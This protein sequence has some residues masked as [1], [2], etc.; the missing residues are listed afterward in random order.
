MYIGYEERSSMHL[1]ET[2][3]IGFMSDLISESVDFKNKIFQYLDSVE[4]RIEDFLKWPD[5]VSERKMIKTLRKKIKW[6]PD[7]QFLS[8]LVRI[9]YLKDALEWWLWA[10]MDWGISKKEFLFHKKRLIKPTEN[11]LF[12][13]Q[14]ECDRIEK[15][16]KLKK[17]VIRSMLS[18]TEDAKV[19]LF[20]IKEWEELS[21]QLLISSFQDSLSVNQTIETKVWRIQTRIHNILMIGT[22][23]E[24]H[25]V[26][27]QKMEKRLKEFK[28]QNNTKVVL[29]SSNLLEIVEGLLSEWVDTEFV[30]PHKEN[31]VK[32]LVD[33][34]PKLEISLE[35]QRFIE[36]I[37]YIRS[38]AIT[39][40]DSSKKWWES[41]GD[42]NFIAHIW[43]PF[44]TRLEYLLQNN[45]MNAEEFSWNKLVEII[46]FTQDGINNR[47]RLKVFLDI[48]GDQKWVN[49]WKGNWQ[50]VLKVVENFSQDKK[51]FTYQIG[52]SPLKNI[53]EKLNQNLPPN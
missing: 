31:V 51:F 17:V 16:L 1:S 35:N 21:F 30:V 26:E 40:K 27:L 29:L 34:V 48:L 37:R 45:L 43:R 39:F 32:P 2:E 23:S 5:K 46:N 7:D 42:G 15:K 10:L 28:N 49:D 19:K 8:A 6:I 11:P 36:Y 3:I 22:I 47:I 20:P 50:S 33:K 53:L 18:D 9:Q 12:P 14:Q 24:D 44:L 4:S 38:E 13:I 25:I 52:I 41:I